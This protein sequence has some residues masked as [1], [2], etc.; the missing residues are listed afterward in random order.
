VLVG[1]I[2]SGVI[3]ALHDLTTEVRSLSAKL[4]VVQEDIAY[5]RE[6]REKD[7]IEIKAVEE[8]IRKIKEQL[9]EDHARRI[10]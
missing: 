5:G 10:R 1:V 4:A 9:T 3:A 6:I 8:D 7:E 2:G